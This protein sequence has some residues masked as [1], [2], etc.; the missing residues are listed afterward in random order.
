MDQPRV[1]RRQLRRHRAPARQRAGPVGLEHDVGAAHQVEERG[2]PGVGTQVEES[3][4]LAEVQIQIQ[5][6][7]RR[8]HGE[9]TM[10]TSAP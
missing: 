6:A 8:Q 10:V 3:Q 5:P 1:D 9:R 2:A 4:S 7:D